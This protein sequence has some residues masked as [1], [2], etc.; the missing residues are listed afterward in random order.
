[1]KKEFWLSGL[2]CSALALT[3]KAQQQYEIEGTVH[4]VPKNL[5][6]HLYH[7]DRIRGTL[8]DSCAVVNG[9]FTFKGEAAGTQMAYVAVIKDGET[10]NGYMEQHQSM[11]KY[12]IG[13][14]LEAGHIQ[15]SLNDTDQQSVIVK[16]TPANDVMQGI[17][18]TIWKYTNKEAATS[19]ALVKAGTDS[20]KRSAL[21]AAYLQLEKD[22]SLAIG[23][24]IKAH[25]SSIVS[26]DLLKRWIDAATDL[27]LA[28]Q[29]YGYLSDSL[30]NTNG[31][32][33]YLGRIQQIARVDVDSLAPDFELRDTAGVLHKLNEY[34]G[35]Y[36]LIDFWASWCVP[37]MHEMPHVV[38]AYDAFRN[39]NFEIIGVSLDGGQPDSQTRWLNAVHKAGMSWPQWSDLGGWGS[40][41][42][43]LYMV[44]SIPANFLLDPQGKI[45][46][47]NLRGQDLMDTLSKYL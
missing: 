14:Y 10:L 7:Q 31:A 46:A 29:L 41:P 39:K 15:L 27:A 23:E 36:V 3:A 12:Q 30:K 38:K 22:K 17:R 34:K 20:V 4:P 5:T 8:H 42:A 19:E 40:A 44:S 47:K 16:G 26:V 43:K 6:L 28:R 24:Y 25:P 21:E 35:K 9:R 11:P 1:M 2:L 33:M 13:V 32:K 37:C 18:P 45:I